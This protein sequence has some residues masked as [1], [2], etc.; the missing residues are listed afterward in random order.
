MTGVQTCALPILFFGRKC[1]TSYIFLLFGRKCG[2]SYIFFYFSVESVSQVTV[3]LN[4][5]QKCVTSYIFIF[6]VESVSQVDESV[7]QVHIFRIGF[8]VFV[9]H[10]YEKCV[11]SDVF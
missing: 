9:T 5:G 11:T 4:F 6:L 2:T 7:S 8:R 1:V 10:F 3:F